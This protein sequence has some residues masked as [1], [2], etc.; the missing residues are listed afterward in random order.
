MLCEING[1]HAMLNSLG[2][3]FLAAAKHAAGLRGDVSQR[4]Y[5]QAVA[6][7]RQAQADRDRKLTRRYELL[8]RYFRDNAANWGIDTSS[9][10]SWPSPGAFWGWMVHFF[11]QRVQAGLGRNPTGG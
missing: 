10:D 1:E 11:K 2:D 7:L 4:A 9:Y 6:Q 3:D 8:L 5:E